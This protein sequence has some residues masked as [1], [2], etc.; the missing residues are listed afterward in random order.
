MNTE[1]IKQLELA[2]AVERG[3][4]QA[5]EVEER[6][7]NSLSHPFG[8]WRQKSGEW[9]SFG[10]GYT[11]YRRKPKPLELWVNIYENGVIMAHRSQ[12]SA[13]DCQTIINNGGCTLHHMRE[14]TN[15]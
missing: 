2:I 10:T 11:E 9:W 14:V 3:E 8:D 13:I 15:E 1:L 4:V 5:N 6:G 7:R 12:D